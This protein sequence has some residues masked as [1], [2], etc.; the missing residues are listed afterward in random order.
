M[1]LCFSIH[2]YY[3]Y[4]YYYYNNYQYTTL[5]QGFFRQMRPEVYSLLI[6]DIPR[7]VEHHEVSWFCFE[8]EGR[9]R[10]E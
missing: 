2:H 6:Q 10:R 8:R 7:H 4:Y 9:R 3:Y 1:W 5:R